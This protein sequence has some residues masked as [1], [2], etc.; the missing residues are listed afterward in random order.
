MIKTNNIDI[1]QVINYIK[2]EIN[3]I[4]KGPNEKENVME[5][6][7]KMYYSNIIDKIIF[8]LLVLSDYDEIQK[9]FIYILNWTL[10]YLFFWIYL[11]KIIIDNN[12]YSLYD[13]KIKEKININNYKQFLKDNNKMF[14]DYLKIYL[15]KMLLIKIISKYDNNKDNIFYK[16]NSLSIENLFDELNMQ[17]LYKI[18]P[19]NNNK[20][21]NII[22]IFEIL[23]KFIISDNSFNDKDYIIFDANNIVE[24]LINNVV[25]EK[26]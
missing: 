8:L 11:R 13:D 3:I 7:K 15:Q 5:N 1:N 14:I 12:F 17:N 20:E 25:K 10:P 2:E 22:D 26:E 21:I 19:K 16:I 24:L 4:I 23:P 18:L 9:I 6:Y